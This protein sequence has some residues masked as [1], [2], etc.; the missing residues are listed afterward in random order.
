MIIF[1]IIYLLLVIIVGLI[2][3]AVMQ[4]RLVGLNVKDFWTFIEANQTLDKLYSF[5]VTYNNLSPQ[6]QIIFMT[7]A[8]KVFD[9]FEKVPNQL[10]EEDYKKYEKVLEIYKGIRMARWITN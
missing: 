10:W 3:Y 7:E 9:A 5:S 6:E 2:I 4:L 1:R 8:E